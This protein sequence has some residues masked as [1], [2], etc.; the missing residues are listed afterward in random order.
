MIARSNRLVLREGSGLR[1]VCL[2]Y[3]GGSPDS[4]RRLARAVPADWAVVAAGHRGAPGLA[5]NADAIAAHYLSV[6][7]PDLHGRG[8]LLGHSMGA[9]IAY[10]LARALGPAWPSGFTLVLSA[11]PTDFPGWHLLPD[12]ELSVI[13]R[14]FGL[15]PDAIDDSGLIRFVLPPLRFDLESIN[16]GWGTVAP[17]GGPV[18]I[19]AG[20]D[21]VNVSRPA[22]RRLAADLG[23][24][25]IVDVVG[26]HMFVCSEPEETARALVRIARAANASGP[27]G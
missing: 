9:L 11:P 5:P 10:R 13:A 15:V 21:D 23:A 17:P 6:L 14:S 2:P 19:I 16:G 22:L 20:T 12:R 1:L 8:I 26:P 24:K 3:A 27:A 4:F 18:H 25:D 7:E